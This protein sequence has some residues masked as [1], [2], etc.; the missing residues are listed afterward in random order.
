LIKLLVAL[1][2]P[3]GLC[4]IG[5]MLILF[6]TGP[7][8]IKWRQRFKF[9]RIIGFIAFGVAMLHAVIGVY[10]KYFMH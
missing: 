8:W 10:F 6:I 3:L 1:H 5:L 9:H 7:R 4:A 2:G